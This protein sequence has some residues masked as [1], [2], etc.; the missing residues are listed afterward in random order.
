MTDQMQAERLCCNIAV[1]YATVPGSR[2]LPFVF[3]LKPH[4]IR[5][6]SPRRAGA[7]GFAT[8]SGHGLGGILLRKPLVF[9]DRPVRGHQL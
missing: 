4:R 8:T 2:I 9:Y 7:S 6:S 5:C 3:S 1:D